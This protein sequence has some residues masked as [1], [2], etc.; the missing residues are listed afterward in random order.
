MFSAA[1]WMPRAWVKRAFYGDGVR[2]PRLL[3]GRFGVST[4]AMRFRID[5][6]GLIEPKEVAA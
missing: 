2:D 5:E 1:L 4:Q 3:A 6:L